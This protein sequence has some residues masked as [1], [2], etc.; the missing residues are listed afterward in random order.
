VTD[1]AKDKKKV[2]MMRNEEKTGKQKNSLLSGINI[3]FWCWTVGLAAVFGL[4]HAFGA[5]FSTVVG[6]YLGY[7]V[8]RLFIRLIGQILSIV[9]TIV[10]IVI[11]IIIITLIIV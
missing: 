6:V 4:I 5:S 11:L 8:L 1:D 9:F 10:F 2:M 7:K 3:R